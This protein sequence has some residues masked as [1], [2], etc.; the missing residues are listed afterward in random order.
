[1]GNLKEVQFKNPEDVEQTYPSVVRGKEFLYL[2]RG[3]IEAMGYTEADIKALVRRALTE[4]GNKMFEM[5]AK[6]GI[7]P[8]DD[9]FHHAMPAFVP[10]TRASGIKWAACF[11]GNHKYG[12]DQTS[13]LI[14]MNDVQT[15]WPVAVMD[16][17]WITAKRTA[18]V[19]AIAVELLARPNSSELGIL[20]CGVQ[21]QEHLLSIATVMHDLKVV[22]IMDVRPGIARQVIQK[23][24][25]DFP[26]EILEAGSAQA[27]VEGSDVVVSATA[28]LKTPRPQIRDE[29]IKTGA[30]LL[31]VDF[32]SVFEWKTMKR[33]DKFLVDSL[34]EMNYFM[35]IG[36]L[37]HGLPQ[38]YAEIGEVV[39][40]LK[41]GRQDDRETIFDMNIGMGVVDV[42]VAKNVL[43]KAIKGNMGTK[44]PL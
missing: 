31:P 22:K 3:Q 17:S 35:S 15:G 1:M 34:D 20:G 41:S 33:A 14:I 21:G 10:A 24:Q 40:G 6:I 26:F 39:A 36:Y 9:T 5:P 11:P 42:V 30:L 7:H 13:G 44:L 18:A 29:W 12:L 37:A 38:L 23:F 8:I 25:G 19:S 2:S 28:I 32:D 4:H 43:E 27:L 16:A